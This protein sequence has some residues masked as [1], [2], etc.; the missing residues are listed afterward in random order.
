MQSKTPRLG[1]IAQVL[2]DSDVPCQADERTP[3]RVVSEG[4]R[5]PG[6]RR[7]KPPILVPVARERRP[8]GISA[9]NPNPGR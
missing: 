9:P 6:R 4:T 2:A 1:W 7:G 5:V 3:L 8:G